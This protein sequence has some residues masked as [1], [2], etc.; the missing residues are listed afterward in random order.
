MLDNAPGF[1]NW[2]VPSFV[3]SSIFWLLVLAAS[4]VGGAQAQSAI[5]KLQDVRPGQTGIGRTVFLGG[6]IEEFQ[7]EILGVLENLGPRQSL[8]LGRLSGGPL[9][10][11]GVMQGMSGS[12]VYVNGKL[13]GAVALAFPFSKQ[14][15]AGIRPIEEMLAA[16]APPSA[17]R[18][19]VET[20]F[21]TRWA[22]RLPRPPAVDAGGS[23]L[24][25]V[26]TP[27]SLSGFTRGT[28]EQFAPQLEALGLSPRQ[29]QSGGGLGPRG[30]LGNPANLQPGSMISVQLMSGDMSVGADGTVT[31]IDGNRIWAFGH[32]FL[33]AGITEMPFARA[34]V[35][36]L[37]PSLNNS[38]KIS[39]AKE[40]MG[41][42]TE[43]RSTAVGGELG[44]RASR[45]VPVTIE[46]GFQTYRM[47]MAGDRIFAPMLLQMAIF[48]ILDT[49]ERAMGPETI[50]VTG[51]V[52]FAG[53]TPVRIE[54]AYAGDFAV[55][56]VAAVNTATPL[57]Y[58]MSAAPDL[59]LE[60]VQLKLDAAPATTKLQI[61][62]LW[63]VPKAARPGQE[64]EIFATLA[65]DAQP[66]RVISGKFRVPLHVPAGP[67]T[68]VASDGATANVQEYS[69]SNATVRTAGQAVAYLN[70]MRSA[71][72]L[73]IR[74]LRADPAFPL[75][76]GELTDPPPSLALLL[77]KSPGLSGTPRQSLL[78]EIRI[79]TGQPVSNSKT[80]QLEIKE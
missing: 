62:Q 47:E 33:A 17:V 64:V 59:R 72:T 58:A 43:D 51:T 21:D 63:T 19:A 30:P 26:A 65:A 52:T 23:R 50:R 55:S 38:F 9:A 79:A 71:E 25:E 11:T 74:I 45:L 56:L 27:L 5:G 3:S 67:V 39:S 40:W 49:R 73:A 10:E 41:V 4:T 29:G 13:I 28:L 60:R 7:V 34:E 15:I 76:G 24:L 37:L 78:S 57:A 61:D 35:I 20:P 16:T 8:I 22:D 70:S 2:F 36:T 66:P 75:P 48:S 12:P 69:L 1:Y 44:R 32:R 6:K 31:H 18:A 53:Q 54:S 80:I 42:I 68:V 46:T 14:A 77:A